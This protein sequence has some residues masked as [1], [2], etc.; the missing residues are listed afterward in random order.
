[1]C[2]LVTGVQTFALPIFLGAPNSGKSSLLNA[3]ARRDVAII[4]ETAG[5]TRDV[6]EVQL[7]LAGYPVVLADTA[8]LRAMESAVAAGAAAQR[9]EE[10]R[11]GK[12]CVRTCRSR[13]SPY[14]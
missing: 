7:D 13:W 1:M 9:S 10:R 6:V 14:H 8:G 4:S 3:V 11:V 2:A 12:E 5:T